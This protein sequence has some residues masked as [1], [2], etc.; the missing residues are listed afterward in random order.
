MK[1]LLMIT[2]I[3]LMLGLMTG[4]A[5]AK[6]FTYDFQQDFQQGGELEPPDGEGLLLREQTI[7]IDIY[8]T[9]WDGP[10]VSNVDYYFTCDAYYLDVVDVTVTTGAGW[11]DKFKDQVAP[12]V[13]FLGVG[14][15]SGPEGT[16]GPGKSGPDILLHTITIEGIVVPQWELKIPV[17][18]GDPV[19]DNHGVIIDVDE[20]YYDKDSID[21]LYVGDASGLIHSICREPSHE[22]SLSNPCDRWREGYRCSEDIIDPDPEDSYELIEEG[23]FCPGD[24]VNVK[25]TYIASYDVSLE[26]TY[27]SMCD[28]ECFNSLFDISLYGSDTNCRYE[29]IELY[30]DGYCA[31][32]V[33]ECQTTQQIVAA[34]QDTYIQCDGSYSNGWSY[35]D[36]QCGLPFEEGIVI[37]VRED[38]A[39][40]CGGNSV[41]EPPP[42]LS[43]VGLGG[44]DVALPLDT[45]AYDIC[46]EVGAEVGGDILWSHEVIVTDDGCPTS[47]CAIQIPYN[48]FRVGQGHNPPLEG[49]VLTGDDGDYEISLEH[50][51]V[52]PF[53]PP[54]SLVDPLLPVTVSGG[55]VTFSLDTTVNTQPEGS[56]YYWA[57]VKII[58]EKDGGPSCFTTFDYEIDVLSADEN[59]DWDNDFSLES[60]V[61][62]G[63]ARLGLAPNA[64]DVDVYVMEE[65]WDKPSLTSPEHQTTFDADSNGDMKCN[66]VIWNTETDPYTDTGSLPANFDIVIDVD[67]NQQFNIDYD[68][69]DSFMICA[70]TDGDGMCD[71]D[72][73]NCISHSNGPDEGTCV[74]DVSGVIVNYTVGDPPSS[75]SCTS[76]DDCASTGGFCQKYQ[77][78]Y[79]GNGI[80]DACEGYADV[81]GNGGVNLADLMVLIGEYGR[82]DCN[83]D[84]LPPCQFDINDDGRV[85]AWDFLILLLQ[86]G[87]DDYE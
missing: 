54:S 44:I 87:G 19:G 42:Q 75:V 10:K 59:C 12:G 3:S 55:P 16:P 71:D 2:T 46:A 22:C 51:D 45:G 83:D 66:T 62:G 39:S 6:T 27:T 63:A 56:Q 40:A 65:D 32:L 61:Y 58:A 1:K 47:A 69:I 82:T 81:D 20:N 4:P 60:T 37:R 48:P 28:S 23:P 78:D 35:W 36:E 72:E 85:S 5:L 14:D 57:N 49:I 67:G 43:G 18:L 77:G 24:T 74:M 26:E 7:E 64:Q 41:N 68:V 11:T 79:N 33:D 31:V 30:D 80:G 34:T 70:G 84:P 29:C 9:D 53:D 52:S 21:D 15:F 50:G 13:Y 38:H 73:D 25:H 8:L 86:Y 76:D 17:T